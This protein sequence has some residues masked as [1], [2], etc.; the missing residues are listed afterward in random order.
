MQTMNWSTPCTAPVWLSKR[1]KKTTWLGPP[2]RKVRLQLNKTDLHYF[3]KDVTFLLVVFTAP[4]NL[5]SSMWK[6]KN[7][8][9][10]W[11]G[12]LR[13]FIKESLH[14][15]LEKNVTDKQ[16]QVKNILCLPNRTVLS[17]EQNWFQWSC[18]CCTTLTWELLLPRHCST[19][20]LEHKAF[21]ACW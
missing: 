6:Y 12:E 21:S 17:V 13:C 3:E 19:S 15:F 10:M 9:R 1:T 18:H 20:V 5:F 11:T 4:D 16:A 8:A 14:F 7:T 2:Q